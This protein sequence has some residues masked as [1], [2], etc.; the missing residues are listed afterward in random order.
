M[1]TV[2][3]PS[4]DA[5]AILIGASEWPELGIGGGQ[6]F[7]N[8]FDDFR[9]YLSHPNGL[10]LPA[11]HFYAEFDS[12]SSPGAVTSAIIDFFRKHRANDG[13]VIRKVLLYLLGQ[14]E[15]FEG[16][17][18]F[19]LCSSR[20]NQYQN[21]FF[22]AS[23]ISKL[24]KEEARPCGHYVIIDACHAGA[25]GNISWGSPKG[26]CLLASARA[27]E[28]SQAKNN[29][30]HGHE[31]T[32]FTG[33]MLDVLTGEDV[34]GSESH[35]GQKPT[36]L[37]F[38]VLS[39]RIQTRVEHL[40]GDKAVLPELRAVGGPRI[41]RIA[42]LPMVPM[43]LESGQLQLLQQPVTTGPVAPGPKI[44]QDNRGVR[45]EEPIDDPDGIESFTTPELLELRKGAN[46]SL[47]EAIRLAS[48][49]PEA[50]VPFALR[51]QIRT[52]KSR[53]TNYDRVLARRGV[54][55]PN[56]HQS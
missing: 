45:P 4:T 6:S 3:A 53:I 12:A 56:T 24:L 40:H 8:S 32:Q 17:F 7:K 42:W 28:L 22:S 50:E 9:A 47:R 5:L 16:D 48:P 41:E 29:S 11:S 15:L 1:P 27:S 38:D 20:R 33:A 18:Y 51:L 25:A 44:I 21:T 26:A 36:V 2:S 54:I 52:F 34:G 31:R 43:D 13:T 46:E 19:A 35:N 10:A 49:Y 39:S 14:G 55:A 23:G 30:P 37:S